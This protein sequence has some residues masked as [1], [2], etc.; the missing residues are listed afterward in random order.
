MWQRGLTKDGI[1]IMDAG[2]DICN[3]MSAFED[4]VLIHA[5][6]CAIA[7][8]V[9]AEI[10]FGGRAFAMNKCE[11]VLELRQNR[12]GILDK[13]NAAGMAGYVCSLDRVLNRTAHKGTNVLQSKLGKV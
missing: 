7:G 2:E 3:S 12:V 10:G 5:N 9:H 6:I 4:V 8:G 1:V 13:N 11:K